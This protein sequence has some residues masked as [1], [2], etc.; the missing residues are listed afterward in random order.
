MVLNHYFLD[1]CFNGLRPPDTKYSASLIL[2][3]LLQSICMFMQGLCRV[4]VGFMQGLVQISCY[5][6]QGF[7]QVSLL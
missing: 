1:K 7:P 3:V 5:I 4:Y 2:Q 6:M